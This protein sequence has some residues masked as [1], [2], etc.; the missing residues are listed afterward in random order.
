M[1]R[2]QIDALKSRLV[3][4]ARLVE[5]MMEGAVRAFQDGKADA[6]RRIIDESEKRVNELEI[7]LEEECTVLIAQ[8]Q[9]RA[10]DLRTVIMALGITND[11]E[12]MGDHAVNIAQAGLSLLEGP[13]PRPLA[14]IPRMAGETIRMVDQ[15][16]QAYIGEQAGLAQKVCA[17]DSIVD[18]LATETLTELISSMASDPSTIQQ[19]LSL[20]RIAGNLERIADLSTN[21]CEDVIYMVEGRVI[22]HHKEEGEL[23][24]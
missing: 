12:R 15:S 19:G 10:K 9:P 7:E 23:K 17:D 2:Q 4:Y 18:D 3:M 20:L 1:L 11:L 6:L 24:G 5:E 13:A 21:I 14:T 22:K 16:I 8:Y